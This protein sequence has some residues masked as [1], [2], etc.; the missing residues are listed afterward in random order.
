METR[1]KPMDEALPGE[2]TPVQHSDGVAPGVATN[3]WMMEGGCCSRCGR[4]ALRVVVVHGVIT[5]RCD[6]CLDKN[7]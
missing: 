1:S 6:R 3:V 5:T 7:I 4:P 2:E